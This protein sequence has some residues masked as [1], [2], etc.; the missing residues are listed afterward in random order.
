MS[1]QFSLSRESDL[2]CLL[3]LSVFNGISY[4]YYQ[5]CLTIRS[6]LSA[7]AEV[8]TQLKIDNIEVMSTKSL[9]SGFSLVN[10]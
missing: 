1:N 2:L 9:P 10:G 3:F 5:S 4:W 8:Y 6:L 7:E